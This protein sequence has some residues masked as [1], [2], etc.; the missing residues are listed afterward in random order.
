MIDVAFERPTLSMS[1]VA[2]MFSVTPKTARLW[3]RK[4]LLQSVKAGGAR[5]TSIQAVQRFLLQDGGKQ[6]ES[7][8]LAPA[9]SDYDEAMKSLRERHGAKQPKRCK[10][11]QEGSGTNGG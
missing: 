8:N 11:G 6:D 2:S 7:I 4:G 1:D 9:K 5:R 10:D 3:S